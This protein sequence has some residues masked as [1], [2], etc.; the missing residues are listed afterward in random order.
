M[1]RQAP[2]PL[3]GAQ[4]WCRKPRAQRTG[5]QLNFDSLSVL[6]DLLGSRIARVIGCLPAAS[7][8]HIQLHLICTSVLIICAPWQNGWTILPY[9]TWP[10]LPR[11]YGCSSLVGRLLLGFPVEHSAGF[12]MAFCG[13]SGRLVTRGGSAGVLQCWP[14]HC[15]TSSATGEAGQDFGGDVW[16]FEI[17]LRLL[18]AFLERGWQRLLCL[19][20]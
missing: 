3:Q 2:L 5:N 20:L 6:W 19:F 13:P 11:P 10:P 14:W 7:S 12:C 18:W 16:R 9:L 1:T 15:A 17:R 4:A 8:T